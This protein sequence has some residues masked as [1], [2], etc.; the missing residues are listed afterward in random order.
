MQIKIIG[1]FICVLLLGTVLP[2]S[3]NVEVEKNPIPIQNNGTL[4]GY[5]YDTS[6]NPI[7]EALVRVYFHGTYEEDYTNAS[8]YYHVMNIPICYCLKNCTAQKPGY[9]KEW[10][11]VG[12]VENTIHDFILA[13]GDVI[14][15]GG[16]GPGN[17]STIQEAIDYA[18]EG[19][20]I[21]VYDDSS[22]YKEN[23]IVNKSLSLIGE[24]KQTTIIEG[25]ETDYVVSITADGVSITGFTIKHSNEVEEEYLVNF[26]VCSDQN[27]VVENI[28]SC[29]PSRRESAIS[30][31]N[32]SYNLI[33]KNIIENYYFEGI[34][35]LNSHYNDIAENIITGIRRRRGIGIDLIDSSNNI[36]KRN[37]ISKNL[38]CVCL[39]EVINITSNNQVIQNN[40]NRY[41][42]RASGAYYS[43]DFHRF[44]VNR[45]N[46]FDENYWDRPRYLPKFI[47]G[48]ISLFWIPIGPYGYLFRIPL[49]MF[50]IHPAR[51]PYDI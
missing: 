7:E 3:G 38:D 6:M 48:W 17:Y 2:V 25:I 13:S 45:G 43:Y 26:Y 31:L 35:L 18:D 37:E 30:L 11:L 19:D 27:I 20:T 14:Y 8:G 28:F 29:D 47:L 34:E 40:F 46:I 49:P 5:V 23:I 21:F 51:K 33:I 10:I 16:S 44:Q 4:S 32:S 39:H 50:D 42:Y 1:I 12:I 41:Y 9:K 22:P 15:V 24:D 36:I